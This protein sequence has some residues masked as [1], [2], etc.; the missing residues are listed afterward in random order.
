MLIHPESKDVSSIT[1]NRNAQGGVYL[2]FYGG[3]KGHNSV[4][5]T[6][7]EARKLGKHL[8]RFA[9]KAEARK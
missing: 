5:L 1:C 8:K 7:A 9:A 6:T 4:D 2:N 3:K